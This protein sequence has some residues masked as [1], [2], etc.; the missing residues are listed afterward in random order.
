MAQHPAEPEETPA[1]IGAS[2]ILQLSQSME[3]RF[4]LSRSMKVMRKAG[5]H[6][7][8][9]GD[10]MI[11][12]EDATALHHALA[13]CKPEEAE[14]LVR[15]SGHRTADYIIAN[16]IPKAAAQALKRLPAPIAGWLL[17]MAIKKHAWTF[18]GSGRFSSQGQCA[19]PSTVA[20][21]TPGAILPPA[22]LPCPVIRWLKPRAP[23]I[24][25][26]TSRVS[27]MIPLV[28]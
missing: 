7:L 15:G 16:R 23:E 21:S 2:A 11:P 8:P 1:L 22:S 13:Y 26:A 4:G 5:L 24:F 25:A 12:A 9:A 19:S 27:P 18:K 20:K 17:M 6:A 3:E 14:A 28:F 10:C